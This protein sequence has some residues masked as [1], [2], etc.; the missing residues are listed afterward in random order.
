MAEANG[1][2]GGSRTRTGKALAILSRLCLPFHHA[3]T[4]HRA[5]FR[6][7]FG[8]SPGAKPIML[9]EQE[10]GFPKPPYIRQTHHARRAGII[11]P[12]SD[13]RKNFL[14][15]KSQQIE[16]QTS[17]TIKRGR[18]ETKHGALLSDLR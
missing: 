4:D 12:Q 5:H 14:S 7:P 2:G 13:K 11:R 3:R 6:P 8:R 9:P 17:Q 16:W 1:A 10:S 15:P 18:F